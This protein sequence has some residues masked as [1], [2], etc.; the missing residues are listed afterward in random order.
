MIRETKYHRRARYL[1]FFAEELYVLALREFRQPVQAIVPVPLHPKREWERTFNQAQVLAGHLSAFWGIPVWQ[2]LRKALSTRA[3]SSLSGR[4]RR[5][6][7][8]GAFTY[9]SRTPAPPS[10]LLVDDVVT[11][12]ATL[13]ECARVLRRSGVR[14]VYAITI[15]RALLRPRS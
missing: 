10:V 1:R 15:A 7:L 12:A 14:C 9:R 2:P 6:N 3:Q 11:T 8:A 4:A 13:S 5:S